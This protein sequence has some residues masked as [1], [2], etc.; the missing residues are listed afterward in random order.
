[1]NNPWNCCGLKA[2]EYYDFVTS[3]LLDDTFGKELDIRCSTPSAWA[4][5]ML[6]DIER[7]DLAQTT[8]REEI[9]VRPKILI[10]RFTVMM[11]S[12]ST[13]SD[14]GTHIRLFNF[15]YRG[16]IPYTHS[17]VN[18]ENRMRRVNEIKLPACLACQHALY[19][20][21]AQASVG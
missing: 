18:I 10:N 21:I 14:Y 3:F 13:K 16:D 9:T 7:I 1:M 11:D 8:C 12:I 6:S 4:G 5:Q 20:S 17:S 19:I 2:L 15:L